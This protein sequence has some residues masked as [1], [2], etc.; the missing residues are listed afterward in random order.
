MAKAADATKAA[1]KAADSDEVKKAKKEFQAVKHR[2]YSR[3]F[4]AEIKV[5]LGRG[6]D[7]AAAHEAG[8]RAARSVIAEY[9]SKHDYTSCM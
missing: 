6:L 3:V 4:K 1:D 9:N 2:L 7:K 5:C 8:G